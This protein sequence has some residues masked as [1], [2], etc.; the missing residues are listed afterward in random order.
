MTV[1][2]ARAGWT[3]A[4]QLQSRG[5]ILAPN[6]T[7]ANMQ[8]EAIHTHDECVICEMLI[9]SKRQIDRPG[10]EICDCCAKALS[11]DFERRGLAVKEDR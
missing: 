4:I 6:I 7:E 8:V 3:T 10:T 2:D 5:W 11:A 9:S 1:A